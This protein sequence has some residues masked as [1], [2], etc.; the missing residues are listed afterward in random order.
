[1]KSAAF[2]SKSKSPMVRS[3]LAAPTTLK[4]R[5]KIAKRVPSKRN[6]NI[7]SQTEDATLLDLIGTHGP[8]HWSVISQSLPGR[9]GKQCRER[10]RNHLSPDINKADW[11]EAEEWRLFL[12]HRLLGNSW[13]TLAKLL[14][15]RTDNCIKNHWNSIM[16]RKM[17]VFEGRL[18][19]IL[20]F[21]QSL[22][23]IETDERNLIS[24]I[25]EGSRLMCPGKQ[26]RKRNQDKFVEE[27]LLKELRPTVPTSISVHEFDK[28]NLEARLRDPEPSLREMP[29]ASL[30]P[31]TSNFR[32]F[33]EADQD[34]ANASPPKPSKFFQP[35][36]QLDTQSNAKDWQARVNQNS[37]L[38]FSAFIQNIPSI[39][40]FNLIM[41]DPRPV[42]CL[43][44]E[45][46]F[47]KSRN[48]LALAHSPIANFY[49]TSNCKLL[50][51]N[52]YENRLIISSMKSFHHLR[53]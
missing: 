4:T 51:E 41:D 40:N 8:S 19:S 42:T 12:L 35:I 27:K 15:N 23:T 39:A 17:P 7:W 1:M 14:D 32:M 31:T 13:A 10:W 5:G 30:S 21:P 22:M 53:D 6:K 34:K 38:N 52:R 26:G 49:E 28:V 47:P 48:N 24:R 9:Q 44:S 2:K 16:K 33:V 11:R 45:M 3:S 36:S 46:E 50:K 43:F 37:F 29:T 25:K 18:Q 20:R